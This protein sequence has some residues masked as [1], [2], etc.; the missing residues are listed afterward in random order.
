MGFAAVPCGLGFWGGLRGGV[1]CKLPPYPPKE[2]QCAPQTQFLRTLCLEVQTLKT[3]RYE[4]RPSLESQGNE[5]VICL[6]SLCWMHL[7]GFFAEWSRCVFFGLVC[8]EL[9]AK[10]ALYRREKAN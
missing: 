4:N 10:K 1:G 5:S 6:S 3:R 9:L 2:K 7:T 8:R